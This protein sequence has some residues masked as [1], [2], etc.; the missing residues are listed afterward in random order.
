MMSIE[1]AEVLVTGL[2][3]Y[4]LI[5]VV[6]AVLFVSLGVQKIDPAARGMP[7]RAR[8]IILPGTMLL[9]PLML[10]KWMTQKEPPVS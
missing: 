7:I 9:W 3:L 10:V 1:T 8:L 5:G 6:F 4:F 2:G